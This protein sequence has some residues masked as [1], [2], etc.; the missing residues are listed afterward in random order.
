MNSIRESIP[1]ETILRAYMDET[2]E[3]DIEVNEVEEQ[4][5]IVDA[6]EEEEP[7]PALV[8]ST[9]L[10]ISTPLT[11]SAP[12]VDNAQTRLSFSDID[13]AVDMRGIES[14]VSAPK[15]LERLE[16]LALLKAHAEEDEDEESDDDEERLKIGGDISLDISDVNDLNRPIKILPPP[17]LDDIEFLT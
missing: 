6:E 10:T 2:D 9:P 14:S 12:L 7:V 15:T 17:I 11:V 8:P 1:V 16:S 3:H 4:I 13:K 5:P